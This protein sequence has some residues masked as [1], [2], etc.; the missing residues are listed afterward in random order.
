MIATDENLWH[1]ASACDGHHML[2]N[3]PIKVDT[4]FFNYFDTFGFKDAFRPNAVWAN[5]GGVHLD[6]L[7]GY[8]LSGFF[9]R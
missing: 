2:H 1:S 9:N 6:A 5:G 4:D 3:F 8:S 7:H